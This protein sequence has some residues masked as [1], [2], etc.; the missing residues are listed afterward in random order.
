MSEKLTA[1]QVARIEANRLKA[2]EKR[3]KTTEQ[4]TAGQQPATKAAKKPRKSKMST[5]YYEYDF[6]KMK[7]TRGG[8]L[9]PAEPADNQKPE[10]RQPKMSIDDIPYDP[11]LH[12]TL[13]CCECD[14]TDLDITYLKIYK[15]KVCKPCIERVPD[16]YSLLTKTEA[17]EDYLL[18]DSELRDHKL[19]PVW[20]RP[21]PHKPTWNNMLLYM[22]R[23]LEAFAI[24][25]WDGLEGLDKE[26][27][28]REEDK[29]MRKEKKYQQSI[30]E[31]RRRTRV[32]EWQKQRRQRLKIATEHVHAYEPTSDGEQQCTECGM[33]IEV[34]EFEL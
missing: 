33:V 26:F 9:E 10:K 8:F 17:K 16:K 22:R 27:E 1:E 34:E 25:K 3:K 14:S 20:E 15:T 11:S 2:L 30:S 23:D 19:F 18:T 4:G 13:R 21:N 32:E 28:R 12:G 5:G 6:S 29:R 24:K 31:L 7:D